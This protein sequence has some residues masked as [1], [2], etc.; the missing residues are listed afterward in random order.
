MTEGADQLWYARAV[1][2]DI[3]AHDDAV[4]IAACRLVEASTTDS[5][6]Q[7]DTAQ[8]RERLEGAGGRT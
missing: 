2:A 1:L 6:E 5:T 4:V 3:A 8:L 7:A